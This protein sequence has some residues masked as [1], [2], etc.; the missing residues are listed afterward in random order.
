MVLIFGAELE[1][2]PTYVSHTPLG[3]V[4]LVFSIDPGCG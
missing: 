4:I 2:L 1:A 3:I